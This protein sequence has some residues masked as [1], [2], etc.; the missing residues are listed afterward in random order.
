MAN[1]Q[2]SYKRGQALPLLRFPMYSLASWNI[3]ESHVGNSGLDKLCPKVFR[4][5]QWTSNGDV[6]DKGSRIIL[7][8]NPNIVNVV[9]ISFDDQVMHMCVH[10][11]ADRKDLFCSWIYA[12]N[13][14]QQKRILWQNLQV[15]KAYI[16]GRSWCLFGD[17]NVSLTTD[18]KSTGTSFVD[19]AM[20]DFQECVEDIEVT[21]VNSSGLRYTWNQKPS[22]MNGILK[23]IDRIMENLEFSSLFEGAS[24][25]FHPYR[26]SDHAP[27]ILRIPMQSP[28]RPR[29][30]KF[31]NILNKATR[32]V[33]AYLNAFNEATRVEE[34]FLQQKAKVEWLKSGDANNAYFHIVVKNQ[35]SRNRIDNITLNN[36]DVLTDDQIPNEVADH[37]VREVSDREIKEAI[38]SMGDD[39]ALGL[40]GYSAAFFKEAWDIITHDVATPMRINDYRPISCCNVLFKCISKIICNRMKDY[41]TGLVSL[42]QSAFIP[43]RRISDNIL[44][45]QELMH[46]YH[47]D[48]GPARC[49]FKV[50]IQKAYDTVD[51]DF[52]KEVLIGFGFHTRMI[53]WIMEC[54]TSTSFSISIN[55]GLY[56]YFKGKRG[57]RQGDLMSP[58][59]FTLAMEILTLMLNKRVRESKSFTYHWYY[60]KLN[61]INLCFADD[62]FLFAHGDANYARVIMDS[63]EEFKDASGLTLSLPKSTG[64]F[65]N[66]LNYVKINILNILPFDE[67]KLPVKYLRVPLVPSRLIYR[68]CSELVE[69]VRKRIK[70]WKNKSLSFAGRVQLIRSILASMH[71][72]WA[73]VFI[74]P[75][76][77]MLDLEQSMRGFLWFQGD[78][79]RGKAKVAWENVCLP[80]H[81]GGL[82]I[83]RLE[84]FNQ[85]LIST[86]IWSILALKET[87]WVKWIHIYK[88]QDYVSNR[89]IYEAGFLKTAK[90]DAHATDTL[91]WRK[92]N[93]EE[94][95]FSVAT[96][97]ESIR[98]RSPSVSWYKLVWYPQ[99]IPRHAILL[100]L[101]IKQKLKTQDRLKQWDVGSNVD[102]TL[103]R[104]PLCKL[105][106]DTYDHLFFECSFSTQVWNRLKPYVRISNFPSSL[107]RIVIFLDSL[108]TKKSTRAVIVKQVLAASCYFIWQERNNRLFAQQSRSLYQV[109]LIRHKTS[110]SKADI[111]FDISASQGYVSG[112]GLASP[113]KVLKTLRKQG[114]WFSFAKR[115]AL[116]PVCIDDN[117]SCIKGW[118][119]SLFFMDL[120]AIPHYMSWMHSNSVITYLKHSAGSYSQ[121]DAQRLS[122]HVVKLCDMPEGVLVLSSRV[123]PMIR[124]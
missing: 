81:E 86:H 114:H 17:F 51:W 36:G 124:S 106:P 13:R 76:Q 120:S 53:G 54:V 105:Q 122:A 14:Y 9:V 12:H 50:D 77:L 35:A 57:L 93:D 88:L 7:G 80:K 8:W 92:V 73:S 20:R 102:L 22:G 31:P 84:A 116:A 47:L 107:S 38:L 46:N 112:L 68:D 49:A 119:S 66:V 70:D 113:A 110:D 67:G 104:C 108:A 45:T 121:A 85:A 96:A 74:L 101:A 32:V 21:D 10:F 83:R 44:L 6:C 1:K 19:T 115:H 24:A 30:F 99:N 29:M 118:K 64:Y 94:V 103:L 2:R 15:H 69:K 25:F 26:I 63:L 28:T 43:G 90:L 123:G 52:L 72:Y 33:A 59:L 82:G 109:L 34:R 117:R 97:W 4:A 98:P 16:R 39:K 61:I 91:V 18:D 60:S 5:W 55:G 65:C 42:N 78:M 62:L 23:K 40:D 75:S 3:R 37:M 111:S 89:D 48:R 71:V 27:A 100:W 56:G 11:K 79:R 95:D 87:L 41:L 58:Y